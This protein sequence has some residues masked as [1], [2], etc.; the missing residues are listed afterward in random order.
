MRKMSWGVCESSTNI[1][2]ELENWVWKKIRGIQVDVPASG[3]DH[4]MDAIRY[5]L[6]NNTDDM[7]KAVYGGG[8]E[9]MEN[10]VGDGAYKTSVSCYDAPEW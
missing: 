6:F 8:N 3:W 4:A 5:W 1:Q 2:N 10:F 9:E 7:G